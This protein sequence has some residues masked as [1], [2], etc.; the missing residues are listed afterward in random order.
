M[1]RYGVG[2]VVPDNVG[3]AVGTDGTAYA[4][5]TFIEIKATGRISR[6]SSRGQTLGLIEALSESPA[7]Q[8]GA[9]PALILITTTDTKIGISTI[10]EANENNVA[11]F[12][13]KAYTNEDGFLTFGPAELLTSP[14][15]E[16]KDGEQKVPTTFIFPGINEVKPSVQVKRG[17]NFNPEDPD[18][19]NFD[20][21]D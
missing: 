16:T 18:L 9:V 7:A 10:Q 6:S 19:I 15:V 13:I 2:R 5:S 14:V 4:N 3:V 17:I 11:V 8:D 12:H 1:R 20:L 21:R